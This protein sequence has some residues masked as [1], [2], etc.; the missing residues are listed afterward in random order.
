MAY[1]PSPQPGAL[2]A[3]GS[4]RNL[5]RISATPPPNQAVSKRDKR[6]NALTDRLRDISANFANNRDVHYRQQLQT[7]QVDMS[8]INEAKPYENKPLDDLGDDIIENINETVAS[9]TQGGQRA[10]QIGS[11]PRFQ[12]PPR[13]GKWAATFVQEVNASMEERDTQLTLVAVCQTLS[14]H[15]SW[16]LMLCLNCIL[17]SIRSIANF[18][19]PG[20]P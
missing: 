18:V 19:M 8:Y 14:S 4:S 2:A 3:A 7:Y 16:P 20:P 10:T 5:P 11:H 17:F 6:K 9:S 1:S 15:V 12:A 13:A